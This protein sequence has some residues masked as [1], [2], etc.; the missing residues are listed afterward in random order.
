MTGKK[1]QGIGDGLL[2][3]SSESYILIPKSW[4]QDDA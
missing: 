3:L 1:K 2:F 4:S